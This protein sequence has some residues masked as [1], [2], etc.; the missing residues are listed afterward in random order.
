MQY[1]QLLSVFY[2]L[3]EMRG[4][5]PSSE[6]MMWRKTKGTGTQLGKSKGDSPTMGRV[7]GK[8]TPIQVTCLELIPIIHMYKMDNQFPFS[9]SKALGWWKGNAN[10]CSDAVCDFPI[11]WPDD[12][13]LWL[14][15]ASFMH[16]FSV[17]GMKLSFR[18]AELFFL[19]FFFL[20]HTMQHV[21]S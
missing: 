2:T 1:F 5:K 17:P 4:V 9:I 16:L 21:G 13:H 6:T 12:T 10:L 14:L 18:L 8:Q 15:Y 20:V 7:W 3:V 11:Q 19:F